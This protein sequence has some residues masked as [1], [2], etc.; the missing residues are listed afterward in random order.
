MCSPLRVTRLLATLLPHLAG[1]RLEQ[2]TVT[3]QRILL[4]ATS[5]RATARCPHC[6]HRSK[7]VHA[8]Y[9]RTVADLPWHG[10]EVCLHLRVRRFRCTHEGCSSKTFAESL[11]D[12]APRYSRRTP[13]LRTM[14]EQLGFAL[15]GKA[16]ARLA[17]RLGMGRRGTSR[18]TLLRLILAAPTPSRPTPRVLG[19]DD[20]SWRRGRRYGTILIDLEQHCPVD[21]LPDRTAETFATWLL[22]HQGVAIISR[23][24]GGAYAEGARQGAPRAV[25]VADRFHLLKNLGEAFEQLLLRQY[26]ALRQAAV[27]AR[28]AIAEQITQQITQQ[29]M[30]TRAQTVATSTSGASA[31]ALEAAEAADTAATCAPAADASVPA[32]D[33][34][35]PADPAADPGADPEAPEEA[36][37]SPTRAKREQQARRARRLARFQA[38]RSAAARGV[39]QREIA[40]RVGIARGTVRK[41][42]R[43][44][45][46]PEP[47]A[48][49]RL[50]CLTS[51]EPYLREQWD[52]GVQDTARLWR[53]LR[54]QGYTGAAS[55]VRGYL[56]RWRTTPAKTGRRPRDAREPPAPLPACRHSPRHTRW[57]LLQPASGL[58][59]EAGS[60]REDASRLQD[61]LDQHFIATL[62]RDCPPIAQAQALAMDFLE[63]VR[64]RRADQLPRWLHA[65]EV[66]G[67]DELQSFARGIQRDRRAV[68]AGLTLEWSN[69]QTEGQVNRLKTLK[70]QMYGRASFPLLRQRLLHPA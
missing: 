15:G 59:A 49:R 63:L 18:M 51:F 68:E 46:F 17:P 50:S 48:R 14:L 2:I 45:D 53:A 6:H 52:A 20:W 30:K 11:P 58:T 19:V 54:T 26:A 21:L 28:R 27:E 25:Q 62:L 7:R 34:S 32:A 41:Y 64:E 23:D 43:A 60:V 12:V 29:A 9:L 33:A 70:R 1:L 39:S 36:V 8:R 67:L 37:R 16:G 61:A 57:L 4:E 3:E 5:V 40:Q 38:V 35:V 24:R 44:V 66:S 22:A 31:A 55:T 56:A 13:S 42:L 65:A 10:R 69:G 47:G